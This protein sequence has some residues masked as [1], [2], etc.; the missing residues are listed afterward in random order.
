[1]GFSPARQR[2]PQRPRAGVSVLLTAVT[3]LPC[4]VA[5]DQAIDC[6]AGGDR[7][8]AGR[9]TA[10]RTILLIKG[11][12]ALRELFAEALSSE[13][14]RVLVAHDGVEGLELLKMSQPDL[15]A[16]GDAMP[17]MD[18]REFLARYRELPGPH[19]PTLSISVSDREL[20]TD[21]T[22]PEPFDLDTFLDLVRRYS[23][24]SNQGS[25]Q[26]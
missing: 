9:V 19:A 3:E 7:R 21:A 15:I 20:P 12:Q 24:A 14:Y 13:G 22:L 8:R 26:G 6:A 23:G 11:D 17:G 1:M 25:A 4:C 10:V 18:G 16:V 2:G 5:T